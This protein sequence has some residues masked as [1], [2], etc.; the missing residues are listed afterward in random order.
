MGPVLFIVKFDIC[1]D[2][3]DG[4]KIDT[5]GMKESLTNINTTLEAFVI[6]QDGH[7]QHLEKILEKLAEK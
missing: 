7:N 3:L 4:I 6:K 2:F 5:G 1:I